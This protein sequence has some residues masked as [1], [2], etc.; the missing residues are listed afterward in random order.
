MFH[1]QEIEGQLAALSLTPIGFLHSLRQFYK[2]THSVSQLCLSC[3]EYIQRCLLSVTVANNDEGWQRRQEWGA[4]WGAECSE[5]RVYSSLP[6][7]N[8]LS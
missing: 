5:F 3:R 7:A 8:R 1:V 2:E 4:E 6:T